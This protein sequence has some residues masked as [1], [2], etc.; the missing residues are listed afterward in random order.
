MVV[1]RKRKKVPAK[2]LASKKSEEIKKKKKKPL[3]ARE[4]QQQ[5]NRS[6]RKGVFGAIPTAMN[7]K[8]KRADRRRTIARFTTA[9][10]RAREGSH[11]YISR[12]GL[13]YRKAFDKFLVQTYGKTFDVDG[14]WWTNARV[15]PFMRILINVASEGKININEKD[16]GQLFKKK[17]KRQAAEWVLDAEKLANCAN[18]MTAKDLAMIFE[19]KPR[20]TKAGYPRGTPLLIPTDQSL[21]IDNEAVRKAEEEKRVALENRT[22]LRKEKEMKNAEKAATKAKNAL[23]RSPMS[24]GRG[25]EASSVMV[26]ALP[27]R[28]KSPLLQKAP[29]VQQGFQP[30]TSTLPP[31]EVARLFQKPDASQQF[32]KQGRPSAALAA[33]VAR[34]YSSD[35]SRVMSEF[36]T[37]PEASNVFLSNYNAL[38]ASELDAVAATMHTNPLLKKGLSRMH[39]STVQQ[40]NPAPK[41]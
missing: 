3:P 25:S 21:P 41:Q 19:G 33:N 20:K 18:R 30:P 15:E 35:L 38:S 12:D 17:D 13:G 24:D 4:E 2:E 39:A 27:G 40:K 10:L 7:N 34:Q 16:A 29:G 28:T 5:K 6:T 23:C 32:T 1:L 26:D 22:K 31:P 37:N 14:Y 11:V 36:N 8:P 9:I